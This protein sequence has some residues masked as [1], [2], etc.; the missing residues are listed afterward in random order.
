MSGNAAYH[1]RKQG[2]LDQRLC[3]VD[4]LICYVVAILIDPFS[5]NNLLIVCD[6]VNIENACGAL[7]GIVRNTV[8][9]YHLA[10]IAFVSSFHSSTANFVCFK[11]INS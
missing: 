9:D 6:A 4:E 7:I 11:D 5:G 3:I 8:D 10:G 1:N 2:T